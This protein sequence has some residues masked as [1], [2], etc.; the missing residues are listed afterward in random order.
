MH[1][2]S[3]M[4][5]YVSI[6]FFQT[7]AFFLIRFDYMYQ[8]QVIAFFSQHF[9]SFSIPINASCKVNDIKSLELN[10]VDAVNEPIANNRQRLSYSLGTHCE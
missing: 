7:S 9:N 6:P 8:V 4:L 1:L 2:F 3:I 5:K 10:K